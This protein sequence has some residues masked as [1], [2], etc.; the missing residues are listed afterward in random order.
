M[1]N[2]DGC[3][4]EG[5]KGSTHL[6]LDLQSL[7]HLIPEQHDRKKRAQRDVVR[8]TEVGLAPTQANNGRRDPD[9]VYIQPRV[10]P[11]MTVLKVREAVKSTAVV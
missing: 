9:V 5:A 3:N 6:N 8:A 2:L 4:T 7:L 1:T 10:D 11:T